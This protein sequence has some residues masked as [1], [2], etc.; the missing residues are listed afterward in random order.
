MKK[1]LF[2]L[3]VLL[4]IAIS[5]AMAYTQ[6]DQFTI[7]SGSA[8]TLYPGHLWSI[9]WSKVDDANPTYMTWSGLCKHSGASPAADTEPFII[10]E[11][12][13]P[14]TVY[15]TGN[16]TWD[17]KTGD[18]NYHMC[19]ASAT[20]DYFTG[21]NNHNSQNYNMEGVTAADWNNVDIGIFQNT[22]GDPPTGTFGSWSFMTNG[23]N[24]VNGSYTFYTGSSVTAPAASFTCSPVSQFPDEVVTCTDTSSNTPTNW[25]WTLDY[26]ALGIKGWQTSTSRNFTWQSHYTGLFGVNLYAS[27]SA[28]GSWYNRSDYVEISLNASPM[29]PETPIPDG[30]IRSKAQCVD[31]MTSATIQS[32]SI[33][34]HDLE[35]GAW[36]NG[37]WYGTYFI[38]TL[39]GHHIN[40]YGSATG[41]TSTSRLN[42]P[43]SS[44][45]MYELLM[46]PGYAPPAAEGNVVLYIIVNDYDTGAP[47]P[48]AQVVVSSSGETTQ[49]KLTGISGQASFEVT[50]SSLW[51]ITASRSGYQTMTDVVQTSAFGPDVDR[52]ELLKLTVN[53]TVTGTTLPG[54][55]TVRPTVDPRLNPDGSYPSN[56]GNLK[57]QDMM[58]WLA[59]NGMDLVQLCFMVTVLAL[60]GVKLGK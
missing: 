58:N 49:T 36:S 32:C 50:N 51:H 24:A 43:A 1:F 29:T 8:Q 35:G 56:Y 15:G 44:E 17:W 47:I 23:Y 54:E 2:I 45:K 60:L 46:V 25:L 18:N 31:A 14:V 4:Y 5:P 12:A 26:D 27:N 22:N 30:Y 28:G 6:Y 3:A 11:I 13:G 52:I 42:L 21:H 48:S 10:K 40:A 38:D 41:Y 59:T 53:P 16:F 55:L 34:L 9:N 20:I 57:G 19:T 7:T 33:A 37:S 39:P